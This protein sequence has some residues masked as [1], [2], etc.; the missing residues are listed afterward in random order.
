MLTVLVCWCIR[1]R[2]S[3]STPITMSELVERMA[4]AEGG[5]L[6]VKTKKNLSATSRF[7]VDDCGC[8]PKQKKQWK[9][10]SF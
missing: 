8:T 10:F 4:E 9:K 7:S 3:N 6:H 1:R 2:F 5:H